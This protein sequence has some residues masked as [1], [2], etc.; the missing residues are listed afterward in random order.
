MQDLFRE[1]AAGVT[2][3][4]YKTYH[5]ETLPYTLHSEDLC[6]FYKTAADATLN[7]EA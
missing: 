1:A 5:D 4:L 3:S 6:L 2:S 7:R